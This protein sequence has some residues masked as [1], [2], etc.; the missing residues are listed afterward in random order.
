MVL[1][2]PKSDRTQMKPLYI[3]PV[4]VWVTLFPYLEGGRASVSILEIP[5]HSP[6]PEGRFSAITQSLTKQLPGVTQPHIP[7]SKR[8]A[9]TSQKLPIGDLIYYNIFHKWWA[10]DGGLLEEIQPQAH[11]G[12]ALKELKLNDQNV[13]IYSCTTLYPYTSPI[14]NPINGNVQKLGV[15]FSGGPYNMDCDS[16]IFPT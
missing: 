15:P 1:N 8:S 16:S 4:S 10:G 13:D 3:K 5:I 14:Y 12:A 6:F 11:S 9:P 7:T 2:S